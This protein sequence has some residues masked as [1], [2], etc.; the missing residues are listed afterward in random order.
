ML[1][2]CPQGVLVKKVSIIAVG[3]AALIFQS[4][5]YRYYA[6]PSMTLAGPALEK[7]TFRPN[8]YQL[9]DKEVQASD[10]THIIIVFPI[11]GVNQQVDLGMIDNAVRKICEEKKFAFMTNVRVYT[12]MWWIPYIYGRLVFTIKGEGW[13]E[14]QKAEIMDGL[15]DSGYNVALAHE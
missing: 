15:K 6:L 11:I 7:S 8:D 5:A 12:K 14:I 13:T 10:V 4:C 2:V 9:S 1:S 3:C